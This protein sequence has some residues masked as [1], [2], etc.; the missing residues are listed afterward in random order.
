MYGKLVKKTGGFSDAKKDTLRCATGAQAYTSSWH[1]T[2][3][4][5]FWVQ[6][7]GHVTKLV[8]YRKF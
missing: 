4:I 1:W 6:G 7:I 2:S 8:T 3:G 5:C